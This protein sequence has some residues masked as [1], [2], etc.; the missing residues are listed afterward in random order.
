M[1]RLWAFIVMVVSLV[2]GVGLLAQPILEQSS[3][4]NEFDNGSIVVYDLKIADASASENLRDLDVERKIN[5][6]LSTAGIRGVSLDL[7]YP[8]DAETARTQAQARISFSRKSSTELA[9]IRRIVEGNGELT[10][11]TADAA[12]TDNTMTGT[13]FFA[14]EPAVVEYDEANQP[15][16]ALKLKDDKVWDEMTKKASAQT[17]ADQQKKLYVWR[18]Y[19]PENDSYDKAFSSDEAVKDALVTDKVLF[20]LD[21]SSAYDKDKQEIKI[22][23]D[24]EWDTQTSRKPWSN[25]G[26]DT[27]WNISSARAMVASI[28]APDYGFEMTYVYSDSI[29]PLFGANGLTYALIGVVSAFVVLACVMIVKYRFA[30]LVSVIANAI[31]LLLTLFAASFLGFEFSSATLVGLGVVA[32]LGALLNANYFDRV[33]FELR[34]G[35]NVDKANFEG[36]KKSFSATF[37]MAALSFVIAMFSFLIGKGLMKVAFGTMIIGSVFAFLFVNY[38]AKWMMYWLTTYAA[39]AKPSLVFGYVAPKGDKAPLFDANKPASQPVNGK[40]E[41][42]PE[43]RKRFRRPILG[44]TSGLVAGCAA[45]GIAVGCLYAFNGGVN[46]IFNPSGDFATTYRLDIMTTAD[47]YQ[48]KAEDGT[49]E[50][51]EFTDGASFVTYLRNEV[52][53]PA[54]QAYLD[55]T[56]GQ[57]KPLSVD[58][59][60][61]ATYLDFSDLMFNM[62][63]VTNDSGTDN[64][65]FKTIYASFAMPAVQG[66]AATDARAQ[67]VSVIEAGIMA[68]QESGASSDNVTISQNFKNATLKAQYEPYVRSGTSQS[69]V[70]EYGLMWFSIVYAAITLFAAV[71][72]SLRY[73]LSAG[74]TQ[75]GA[76]VL[77]GALGVLV[78]ALARI[79]FTSVALYGLVGG[80]VLA[81]VFPVSYYAKSRDILKEA[82]LYKTGTF[83]QRKDAMKE[84]QRWCQG[85]LAVGLVGTIV[86]GA[87]SGALASFEGLGL[88]LGFVLVGGLGWVFQWA[89]AQSLFPAWR[90]VLKFR[91][92]AK[93]RAK[94]AAETAKRK[95]KQIIADPNEAKETVIVGI[96]DYKEW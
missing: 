25:S 66:A 43:D 75:W 29:A 40:A 88:A 85:S 74:L 48:R 69:G 21:T 19:D 53:A 5:D 95:K 54:A 9:A 79:P 81:A 73:G 33:L 86:F 59:Y 61:K 20:T 4:S 72:A 27:A 58:D 3:V 35:R 57:S 93:E 94:I 2:F 13:D 8:E 78:F 96:N 24:K 51:I 34:K 52:I 67:G 91:K 62:V 22:A 23:Q 60:L 44:W 38:F 63:T 87:F 41:S 56:T 46:G 71:Y 45:L 31:S 18:D 83:D 10:I 26:K 47:K 76:L 92:L 39:N 64:S 84:A 65:D 28:N 37:D 82:K 55:P 50:T 7:V 80:L 89:M 11:A 15:Y 12:G 68:N 77:S 32:V 36:Y 14:S 1:R 16:V 42:A 49:F 90:S 6:R 30:G 17:D 70:V